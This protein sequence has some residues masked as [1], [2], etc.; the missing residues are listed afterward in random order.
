MNLPNP[1]FSKPPPLQPHRIQSISM[2]PAL[3]RSLRKRQHIPSNRRPPANKSVRPNPHKMM[4][5]TQ[6]PHRGPVSHRDMPAQSRR[7]RHNNVAPNLAI[8]RNMRI[9][10]DQIVGAHPRTPSTLHRPPVDGDK[11]ADH[12]MVADLQAR[13]FARISNILRSHANRSESKEVI[14][15]ADLR[16]AANRD[17]R[18]QNASLADLDLRPNHAVGRNRARGMYFALRIDNRRRMNRYRRARKGFTSAI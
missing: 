17:M 12:V 16:R 9:R 1:L 2:R 6:S 18:I 15:Q 10:H 14:A 7:V 3:G 11:L 13:R 5:R 8:M 4:H